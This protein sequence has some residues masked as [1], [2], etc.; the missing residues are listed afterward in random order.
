VSKNTLQVYENAVQSFNQFRLEFQIELKWP[1][2]I[3]HIINYV[4]YLSKKRYSST[5]VK[6]YLSG[7]NYKLK[8]NNWADYTNSFVLQKMLKGFQRIDK[9]TDSRKP[10]TLDV[11][12]Q[13]VQVLPAVCTSRFETQL[14]KAAFCLAFFGFLRLGEVAFTSSV[15][16]NHVI[17]ISDISFLK[18]SNVCVKIESSKTDQL[19]NSVTLILQENICKNI[20]P[21]KQLKQYL[22]LRPNIEGHLFCHLNHK[23]LTRFQFLTVLKKA[24][25]FLGLNPL[26]YNT[27][28]FRIGAATSAAIAGTSDENIKCMGRWSS[29]SF[30]RYIR[31]D[32]LVQI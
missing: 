14:F 25:V 16:D 26:D 7:I 28:S 31:M 12:K 2:P 29:N 18:N 1:P 32:N 21:V 30:M 15:S 5:T 19:G 20:C 27:H 3:D 6:T 17:K 10:I 13:L 24:L 22:S 8:I 11:L 23:T 4:A 9:K